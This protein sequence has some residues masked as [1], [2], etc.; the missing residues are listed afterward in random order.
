M[1]L[2]CH[3]VLQC[4]VIVLPWPAL[5]S[6]FLSCLHGFMFRVFVVVYAHCLTLHCMRVPLPW[7]ALTFG[8]Y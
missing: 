7:M 3:F 1:P 2:Q 5:P 8:S 4:P 6:P